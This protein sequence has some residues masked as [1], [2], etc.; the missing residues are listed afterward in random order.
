MREFGD[1]LRVDLEK[2]TATTEKVRVDWIE[3]FYGARGLG[4]RYLLSEVAPGTDPLGP[5]NPLILATGPLSATPVPCANKLEIVT[6]SPA[7]NTILDCSIGGLSCAALRYAGWDLVII[8]GVSS[9]P[10]YLLIDGPKVEVRNAA[11]LWGKG[12]HDTEEEL[13]DRHAPRG[14]ELVSVLTIGLAGENLV[15]FACITSERYRQ[16]GRGGAGAVMGSKRLKAIVIR[17]TGSPLALK[18]GL[19]TLAMIH[20]ILKEEAVPKTQWAHDDGTPALVDACDAAGI[21]PTKNFQEGRFENAQGINL[22]SVKSFRIHKKACFGCPAGCGNVIKIGNTIV[23]GPEYETLALCGANCGI[24]NLEAV[25]RFNVLCDDLGLDTMSTGNVVALAMDLTEKGISDLGARF[26]DVDAYL[27]FPEMIAKRTGVGYQLSLGAKR[28]AEECGVPEMAM[29]V[30]GLELPGYEPRG[31]WGM[32]LAYAT[33]DRGGCHMRAFTV[34][35]EALGDLNPFTIEQKAAI[36][37]DKQNYNAIKWSLPIC[38]F[39]PLDYNRMAE[40]VNIVMGTALAGSDMEKSGERIYNLTRIFNV[41]EGFGRDGLPTRCF[42]EPL[43]G[44]GPA[45]GRVIPRDDFEAML[46]EFYTL[47]GWTESGVPTKKKLVELGL[48][49]DEILRWGA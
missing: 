11:Y 35:R 23:E 4:A 30:K 19:D 14:G 6:K 40:L 13:L 48:D 29:E 43:A 38:D 31:S 39:W 10:S 9:S 8:E 36:T 46:S 16:A 25:A 41:R 22:S 37:I 21:L 7:T 42:S 27:G 3:R 18:G 26:G 47:R 32:G 24:G 49:E 2:K 28:L 33:A 15:P 44:E 34:G 12:C 17:G 1:V 20:K 45:A 5:L